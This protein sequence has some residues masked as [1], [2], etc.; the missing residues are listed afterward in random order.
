MWAVDVPIFHEG[1][2]V[3]TITFYNRRAREFYVVPSGA[4]PIRA[5]L[6]KKGYDPDEYTTQMFFITERKIR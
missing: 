2:H 1:E 5:F 3:F 4:A 6:E